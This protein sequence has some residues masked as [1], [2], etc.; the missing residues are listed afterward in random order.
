MSPGISEPARI[1]GDVERQGF[2]RAASFRSE[3]TVR[4]TVTLLT[5]NK[6]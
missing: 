6:V 1:S 4:F 3:A 5:S 2:G